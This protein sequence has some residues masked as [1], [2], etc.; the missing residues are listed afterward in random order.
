MKIIA[1]THTHTLMSGHAHSTAME[2]IA[3]AKQKGLKFLAITDHTGIMPGAPNDVYFGTLHTCLPELYDGVYLLRGCELNITDENGTVDLPAGLLKNLDWVIASIHSFVTAPMNFQQCTRLWTA[4]AQNPDIDVIGHCGEE[5]FKF[6]YEK[7]IPLFAQSG[8]IV[9]I[10]ASSFRNRPTCKT[11][12]MTIAKLCVKHGVP[13][14]VSSDAH[15]A[16]AV[17]DFGTALKLLQENGIPEEAILN[18]DEKRFAEKL[19]QITGRTFVL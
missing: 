18:A 5:T 6:D 9:E 15:F 17:G 14:V 1:D 3:I 4:V 12:C 13:L 10:N 2:H 19:T 16:G 7:V 8:K 11:N